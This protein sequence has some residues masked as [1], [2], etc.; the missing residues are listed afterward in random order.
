[1]SVRTPAKRRNLSPADRARLALA[2]QEARLERQRRRIEARADEIAEV[3]ELMES[4]ADHGLAPERL[5]NQADRW[6]CLE[7]A[8]VNA[9]RPA[10]RICTTLP[11][12]SYE[13]KVCGRYAEGR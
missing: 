6:E 12:S 1:M 8:R 13:Q 3:R 4:E 11:A 7:L 10:S 2:R 9:G 5:R